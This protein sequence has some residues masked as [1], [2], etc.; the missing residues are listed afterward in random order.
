VYKH[1]S[2]YNRTIRLTLIAHP[3]LRPRLEVETSLPKVLRG[4]N[5]TP[6]TLADCRDA[7]GLLH[8]YVVEVAPDLPVP[9]VDTWE[10]SRVE[11]AHAWTVENPDAYIHDL[12]PTVRARQDA[13]L[14]HHIKN[15]HGGS[16]LERIGA[17]NGW[18]DKLY[19]K[20]AETEALIAERK[21]DRRACRLS[22]DQLRALARGVLRYEYTLERDEI[23]SSLLAHGPATVGRLLH[24]L[25]TQGNAH[26]A[27]RWQDFSRHWVPCAD[28]DVVQRLK[29]RYPTACTALRLMDFWYHAN[30]RG[31]EAYRQVTGISDKLLA[32]RLKG[33][34]EAG[35]GF[36][37]QHDLPRLEIPAVGDG[38]S[39]VEEPGAARR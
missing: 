37:Q 4:E 38:V 14:R 6:F 25:E 8:A 26:L 17:S 35:V 12:T 27:R 11:L 28:A 18:K 22:D 16:G 29:A 5:I 7:L 9:P 3:H 39:H 15:H 1:Q 36:G 13:A 2:A 24:H 20:A 30:G 23:R 31:L 32:E 10:V 21:I 34:R 19:N 33:L